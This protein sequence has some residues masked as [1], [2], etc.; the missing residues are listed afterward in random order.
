MHPEEINEYLKDDYIWAGCSERCKQAFIE[1]MSLMIYGQD[2]TKNAFHHF[3]SGYSAAL[4]G[5]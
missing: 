1:H 2:A 3:Y 4:A 5:V